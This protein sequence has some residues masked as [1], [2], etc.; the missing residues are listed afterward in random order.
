MYY[1]QLICSPDS[2]EGM[3]PWKNSFLN[4]STEQKNTTALGKKKDDLSNKRRYNQVVLRA[5][6]YLDTFIVVY[7]ILHDTT[8]SNMVNS[9]I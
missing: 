3:A 7:T 8:T 1:L 4:L 9:M 5:A 2:R 6:I